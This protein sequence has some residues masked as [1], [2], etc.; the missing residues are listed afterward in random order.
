MNNGLEKQYKEA[1]ALYGGLG[2]DVAGVLEELSQVKISLHC[3]QGD[4]VHGFLRNEAL[5]GGI[6]VT[7]SYPG[8]ARTPQEL[9]EDLEKALSLIPGKHKV[10]LHA[11]YAD[12][13]ENVDLDQLA[14]RHFKSWVEWAKERGLGLDFNPTCFSH[15]KFQDGFTISHS[16]A[17]IRNFWIRHCKISRKIAEYFGKEL[18]QTCV[19]NFWFPDG[20]KDVPIDRMAPRKRMKEA[21]DEVFAEKIDPQ[22]N[23]DAIESKLFGIGSESYVV[24]SHEFCLSYALKNNKAICLDAG[25]FHPTETISNKLSAIA[26]FDTEILLH[27]S[28]P[29]RWDSDHVVIMD[30]E[31]QEIAKELVRNNLLGKTHIGLDYFDASINRVAAWIIGSRNMLKALLRAML[32]PTEILKAAEAEGDLTTRLVMLEEL[33]SYPFGAIWDYYCDKMGVAV[34]ESWLTEVKKYE[35]DVLL[36][37]K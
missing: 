16:Q 29:V 34:R 18:K 33:K 13:D 30:D 23:V 15:P 24:G 8:A 5:S 35:T 12:T 14:P 31:L 7:G 37:R 28:R 10:N 3:W 4:D 17:E 9:R 25:H 19:T 26:L 20:F 2:I 27:V 1:E 11:I 22:Y 36:K 21:L 6:S 32:E